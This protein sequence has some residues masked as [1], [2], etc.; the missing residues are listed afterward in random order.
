[1]GEVFTGKLRDLFRD[2]HTWVNCYCGLFIPPHHF[3]AVFTPVGAFYAHMQNG[4]LCHH[5]H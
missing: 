5:G 3:L 1:V 4:Y 2:F